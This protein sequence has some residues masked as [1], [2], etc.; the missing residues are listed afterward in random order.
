MSNI[1]ITGVTGFVGSHMADF[2]IDKTDDVI[3]ATKRWMEDTTNV[4]HLI[5]NDRF[6]FIDCDLL[7][8]FKGRSRLNV[9]V[10]LHSL[11][12]ENYHY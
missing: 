12:Y 6:N 9:S 10:L 3:F 11:Q 1:L 7:D 5:D 4:E 2:I 8:D